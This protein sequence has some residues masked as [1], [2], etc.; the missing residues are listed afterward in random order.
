MRG[1]IYI[2]VDLPPSM[3]HKP[4]TRTVPASDP[5]FIGLTAGRQAVILQSPTNKGVSQELY[6]KDGI[7]RRVIRKNLD[8]RT[9]RP[10]SRREWVGIKASLKNGGL[11]A[12]VEAAN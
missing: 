3:E 2:I 8:V 11:K 9:N 10:L 6:A 4:T 7:I 1:R 12:I 5:F